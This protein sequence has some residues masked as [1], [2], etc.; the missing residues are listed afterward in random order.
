MPF[1]ISGSVRGLTPGATKVL[2]LRVSNPGSVPIEVTSVRVSVSAGSTPPGCSSTANLVLH[3]PVGITAAAPVAVPARGSV[4]LSRFPRAPRI[5]LRD[6]RTNQEACKGTT[7][8]LS[9]TGSA[10]S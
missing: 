7:F 1:D 4:T 10:H 5:A 3:Q 6:L 9:Y 8:G 2:M